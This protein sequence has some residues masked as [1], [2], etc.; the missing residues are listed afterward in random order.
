M[1]SLIARNLYREHIYGYFTILYGGVY[2]LR[3]PMET[4]IK[5]SNLAVKN[6][7]SAINSNLKVY[8]ICSHAGFSLNVVNVRVNDDQSDSKPVSSP[9]APGL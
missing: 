6:S 4:P 8:V 2:A 1:T 7:S 9:G 5:F 3:H